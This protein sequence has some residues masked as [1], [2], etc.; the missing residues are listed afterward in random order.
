LHYIF[1]TDRNFKNINIEFTNNLLK[2]IKLYK[3]GI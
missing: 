1:N 3:K 2:I